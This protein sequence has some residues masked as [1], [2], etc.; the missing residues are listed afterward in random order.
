MS[1]HSRLNHP[2]R[3]VL[4]EPIVISPLIRLARW[5]ALGLGILWGA[6]HYRQIC[7]EYV[8]LREWEFEKNLAAAKVKANQKKWMD[9]EEMRYIMKVVF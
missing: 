1:E 7:K 2:T 8:D 5:T 6:Y 3:V 4:P 9:K